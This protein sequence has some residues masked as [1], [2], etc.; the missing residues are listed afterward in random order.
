VIRLTTERLVIRDWTLE[1]AE[2]AFRM[3]GDPDVI[4]FLG[5]SEP[6]PNLESQRENLAKAIER[7]A[8][9]P[10]GF[11]FWAVEEKGSGEVVGAVL[12]KPLPLSGHIEPQNGPPDIEIGWHLA[13]A[14]WGRG[15]ASESARAMMENAFAL[16]LVSEL[17]AVLYP[18]NV[19]SARVAE[20]LGMTCQGMT[21]RYY[22][23]QLLHYRCTSK[24]HHE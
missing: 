16:G 11:G 19:R 12:L 6:E 17:T 9:L 10:E 20:R 3:Y 21:D 5:R 2:A 4:R 7:S 15:Y 18:E 14:Y 8:A 24:L 13:K 23:Q 22:D 1:D